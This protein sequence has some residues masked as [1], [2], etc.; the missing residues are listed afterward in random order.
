MATPFLSWIVYKDP[1]ELLYLS[2]KLIL[3]ITISKKELLAELK[4]FKNNIGENQPFFMPF[5][6][7][8]NIGHSLSI[9]FQR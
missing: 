4:I 9:K 6:Y 1:I 8:K 5:N 2:Q 7:F 3:V